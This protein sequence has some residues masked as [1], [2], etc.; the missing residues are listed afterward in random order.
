MAR[1]SERAG[2]QVGIRSYIEARQEKSIANVSRMGFMVHSVL[3]MPGGELSREQEKKIGDQESGKVASGESRKVNYYCPSRGKLRACT[4]PSS[5][6]GGQGLGK[7]YGRG[8]CLLGVGYRSGREG[9][10]GE[11]IGGLPKVS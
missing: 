11:G 10:Q 9:G 3:E 2:P 8:C 5:P 6:R 7:V 4:K 1:G